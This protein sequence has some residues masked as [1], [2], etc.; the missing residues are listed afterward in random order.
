MRLYDL[1]EDR[2]PYEKEHFND[3]DQ[4]GFY[5]KRGAGCIFLAKDTG[6]LLLAHRSKDVL[7]PHTWGSWGG[8]INPTGESPEDAVRREVQEETGFSGP[9]DLQPLL[10]F[11]SGTFKYFNFLAIV[12]HEFSPVLDWE[13]QG[14]KWCEWGKWPSPLHFGLKSLFSDPASCA[15]IKADIDSFKEVD[16]SVQP[17]V[18]PFLNI[19]FD[20]LEQAKDNN[21][22]MVIAACRRLIVAFRLGFKKHALRSDVELVRSF[23]E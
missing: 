17:S 21:D 22:E 9:I 6:R 3:L 18:P 5:G 4:T 20:V 2:D 1:F 15:K 10:V 8:A 11:S 19:V 16:E 23:A 14:Y 7:E 12:D 13:T